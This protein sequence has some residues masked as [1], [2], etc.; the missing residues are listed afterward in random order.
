MAGY[1]T[2]RSDTGYSGTKNKIPQ[3]IQEIL[4]WEMWET[5]DEDVCRPERTDKGKKEH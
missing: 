5:A 2:I 1:N 4:I 3:K